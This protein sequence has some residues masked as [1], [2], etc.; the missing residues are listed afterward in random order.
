MHFA[1]IS[2]HSQYTKTFDTGNSNA[3]CI[4]SAITI[5]PMISGSSRELSD[6]EEAK[7]ETKL[8]KN[9]DPVDAK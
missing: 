7:G 1:F 2:T 4:R 6:D 5:R 3:Y 9:M 8:T